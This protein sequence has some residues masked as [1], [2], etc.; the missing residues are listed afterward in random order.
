MY[1]RT[2]PIF[3]LLCATTLPPSRGEPADLTTLPLQPPGALLDRIAADTNP[4]IIK[5]RERLIAKARA[6]A[7]QPVVRRVHTIDEIKTSRI[8][9]KATVANK[10]P[11]QRETFALAMF[12][13][14]SGGKMSI[15]LP[16]LAAAYRITRDPALRDHLFGQLA[17]LAT[18]APLLRPGWGGG[19]DAS[20]GDGVWLGTGWHIRG[21]TEALGIL[22]PEEIP[23]ALRTALDA[24]LDREIA[25]ILVA[26]NTRRSW[27]FKNNAAHSNQWVL[28][29]E[30]LVLATLHRGALRDDA[31]SALRET[32]ELGVRLL[33]MSLDAQGPGGEFREGLTYAAITLRGLLSSARAMA[34]AGDT[35][36]LRHPFLANAGTWFA[37]HIQPGGF[38]VNAF[39]TLNGARGQLK[40]F[41]NIYAQLIAATGNPHALWVRDTYGLEGDEADALLAAAFPAT[42]ARPPPLHAA[43]PVAPRVVWRSSWDDTYAT[44]IWIRGGDKTDA[45]DHQDRGH[46]NFIIGQKPLL[47]EAGALN[48]ATPGFGIRFRGVPG[49]NV[50][51]V[52]DPALERMTAAWLVRAG[53]ILDDAHRTAPLT[54]HRLDTDGGDVTIDASRCYAADVVTRWIRRVEWNGE[55]MRVRD[56]VAL[57]Q[58]DIVLFRWH[59]G[60]APD[61]PVNRREN[62]LDIGAVRLT[63]ETDAALATRVESAPDATLRARTISEHVTAISRSRD[64]VTKF[65]LTTTVERAR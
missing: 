15:E 32:Y 29:V 18:W 24:L 2:I 52:G 10:P 22:P 38:L 59:T 50:L 9:L 46:V 44:G 56:D 35:R 25:A 42:L 6:D 21:I 36:A 1:C 65:S 28:P 7:A 19:P 14:D 43:W 62:G 53:Q 41:G 49:H 39:D 16:R 27:F 30:G 40:I 33:A 60:E 8:P 58:P 34:R 61:A 57:V 5:A 47:I 37:H 63:W 17:E 13:T 45:H 51:Q 4:A 26:H 20:L 12:D 23:P 54:V 64:P 31:P 3:A 11:K 48:Y 55:R